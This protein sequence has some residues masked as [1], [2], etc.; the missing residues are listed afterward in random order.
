M[1]NERYGKAYGDQ[2][3][4]RIGERIREEVQ[5]DG[6]IAFNPVAFLAGTYADGTNQVVSAPQVGAWYTRLDGADIDWAAL[7]A[8]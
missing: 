5:G 7:S 6:G 8:S 2:V 3:L 4:T 1:I